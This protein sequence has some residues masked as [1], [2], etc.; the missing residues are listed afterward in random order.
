[1]LLASGNLMDHVNDHPWPGCTVEVFG[2]PVTLMSSGIFTMILVAIVLVSLVGSVMARHRNRTPDATPTGGYNVLETLVVFVRDV[3][4]KPALHEKADA[5]LPFLLTM[6]LFIL[7]MNLSG[8]LPL[9]GIS[10][11]LPVP[12]GT[13]PTGILTVC[14][15]LASVTLGTIV[16]GGFY[17]TVVRYRTHHYW[18][19]WL[20][21]LLS[22]LL[23]VWSLSPPIEGVTGWVIRPF[24]MVLELVGAIAK[25]F[26]LVIRMFANLMAG[27]VLL[28]VMM[29][30]IVQG[31]EGWVQDLAG[32]L[33]NL[34]PVVVCIVASVLIDL[35]ELMVAGLQAYIFTF[36]TA[37][38]LGLYAGPAQESAARRARH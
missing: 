4:A 11:L 15:G 29:M 30:F 5:F 8:L 27:H 1:M 38:F 24:L 13:T 23:W 32:N 17:K 9:Q 2:L 12:I 26:A 34:A 14:A 31:L 16:F 21:I 3:I 35:M 20:A 37:I 36:L 7:G 22:P 6:F 19:M 33:A 18:P 25:C 28:A 10:G